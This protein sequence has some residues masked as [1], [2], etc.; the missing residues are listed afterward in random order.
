MWR[1]QHQRR[2]LARDLDWAATHLVRPRKEF[3]ALRLVHAVLD[4]RV[5]IGEDGIVVARAALDAFQALWP[6]HVRRLLADDLGKRALAGRRAVGNMRTDNSLA[7]APR[8]RCGAARRT[9]EHAAAWSRLVGDEWVGGAHRRHV[10]P[11]VEAILSEHRGRLCGGRVL[12][13]RGARLGLQ[14]PRGVTFAV[15]GRSHGRLSAVCSCVLL[16]SVARPSGRPRG[17]QSGTTRRLRSRAAAETL[18]ETAA[19]RGQLARRVPRWPPAGDLV[20]HSTR[21]RARTPRFGRSCNGCSSI[22]TRLLARPL[23]TAA[24][25]NCS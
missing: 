10:G 6:P 1:R 22:P 25:E 11:A 16:L 7:A 21:R 17:R 19:S 14:T 18:G 13:Q 20:D 15:V 9:E 24:T 2:R 4:R 8:L 3:D 12:R 23:C 5:W